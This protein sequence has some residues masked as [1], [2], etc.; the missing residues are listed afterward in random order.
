MTGASATI[1]EWINI[2]FSNIYVG[3]TAPQ[4]QDIIWIDTGNGKNPEIPT[5]LEEHQQMLADIANIKDIVNKLTLIM[6]AGA[7][8][9]DSTVGNDPYATIADFNGLTPGNTPY[10]LSNISIK[11]DTFAN[12]NANKNHLINGELAYATDTQTL[13]ILHNNIL[14]S[15][16]SANNYSAG[17]IM[18]IPS[19]KM[20]RTLNVE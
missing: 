15:L 14:V 19:T 2:N 7:R 1:R 12:L 17:N 5:P 3:R 16:L 10:T 8:A 9:G 6:T 20:L 18:E 4:Y 11:Y 13:Y